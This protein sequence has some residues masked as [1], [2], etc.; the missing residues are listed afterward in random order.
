MLHMTD[1]LLRLNLRPLLPVFSA[2]TVAVIVAVRAST[3]YASA[4]LEP[5]PPP[6]RE[7][8]GTGPTCREADFAAPS[9]APVLQNMW[10][11]AHVAARDGVPPWDER[12]YAEY[13]LNGSRPAGEKMM[14]SRLAPLK[15]L[16][17]IA[18]V[19]RDHKY[20][21]ALER[22]MVTL[23][24][25]PAWILPAHVSSF[26]NKNQSVAEL[27]LFG[28]SIAGELGQVLYFNQDLLSP[29]VVQLVSEAIETR[30]LRPFLSVANTSGA[31]AWL[32]APNNWNVVCLAG[33]VGAAL[34]ATVDTA[35]ADKALSL[36]S[37]FIPAYFDSFHL[38]G[39]PMES[40]NYWNYGVGHLLVLR[41]LLVRS[42]GSGA[43][44]L[45]FMNAVRIGRYPRNI[46]MHGSL[47]PPFGDTRRDQTTDLWIEQYLLR[48]VRELDESEAQATQS[49]SFSL[50]MFGLGLAQTPAL[51]GEANVSAYEPSGAVSYFPDA[52]VAVMRGRSN[53]DVSTSLAVKGSTGGPHSHDDIG[54]FSI[55]ICDILLLGD[56]GGPSHYSKIL[57]GPNKIRS[58]FGHPLPVVDGKTMTIDGLVRSNLEVLTAQTV[59]KVSLDLSKFYR[60]AALKS[61]VRTFI[62]DHEPPFSVSITDKFSFFSPANFASAMTII[63]DSA[64]QSDNTINLGP[65]GS[66][67]RLHVDADFQYVPSREMV[68]QN[69]TSFTRMSFESQPAVKRGM[70]SFTFYPPVG[71]CP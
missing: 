36:A 70:L 15:A 7:L 9:I 40:T 10:V 1:E 65:N 34:G 2:V 66:L 62:F 63:V 27:D 6:G 60:S 37:R 21:E 44:P 68:E 56:P 67:G 47:V 58:S 45:S 3:A 43:D 39:F 28:A 22:L 49:V 42:K 31:P 23:A 17:V 52:R 61:L 12:A 32:G 50:A 41:E 16:A 18:C 69:G 51:I 11:E 64:M 48:L 53:N 35:I 57:D 25:Q 29:S 8:M 24:E 30:V 19:S 13:R 33:V 14:Y 55:A 54:S 71:T 46:R 38:D 20:I 4:Y 5:N 26:T 59:T